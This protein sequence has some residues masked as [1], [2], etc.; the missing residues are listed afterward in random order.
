MLICDVPAWVVDA[1]KSPLTPRFIGPI[2]PPTEAVTSKPW[3]NESL[4]GVALSGA[5]KIR[6]KTEPV[7]AGGWGTALS[8][9][10]AGPIPG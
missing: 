3:L 10:L 8:L 2:L 1:L 6:E 4:T 7:A 5:V 9:Y